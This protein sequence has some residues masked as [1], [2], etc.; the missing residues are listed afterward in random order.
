MEFQKLVSIFQELEATSSGNQMREILSHFLKQVP[1]EEIDLVS[2]L[3]LGQIASQYRDINLGMAE[4]MVIK[5]LSLASGTGEEKL[6]EVLKQKGDLGLAAEILI[7]KKGHGLGSFALGKETLTV[8]KVFQVLH[9]ISQASGEGSQ[10]KKISLLASLLKEASPLEA[11]YL[12]RIVLGTLRLGVAAMTVLDALSIA[13]TGTKANKPELEHAYNI[14]PDIGIIA[15]TLALKG[16]KGISSI[17]VVVGRPINMMLAQRVTDLEEIKKHI[18]G[19]VSTEEKYDGERIQA[20]QTK[21]KIILFSRRM[22][23]I[24]DQFPDVV[25]YLHQSIKAKEYVIEGEVVAID[26]KGNLLPFQTLMQ[27]RRKYQVEKYVKEIPIRF[28]LFDLLYLDGKSYLREPYLERQKALEKIVKPSFHLQIAN[29]ITTK[30]LDKIEEFFNQALER[31]TEGII[32]KSTAED[33]VYQAGTRGWLWIKWKREYAKEIQ[34]TF[35]L[36]IVGAFAGR[37]KRS[38]TYGALLCAAYNDKKDT[39]ETVCKLGSGFSD[40]QLFE[41]PKKLK[42][43][44]IPHKPARLEIHK[45]MKPD[46]WFEP[47]VVVEVL[48]AELTK[49]PIHTCNEKEGKGIAL[50]FPRFVRLR[51]DKSPEQATT[52]HE[53][54]DMLKGKK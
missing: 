20:H 43:Y 39:F 6:K 31:G 27:R 29:K 38:G 10:E 21:N 52:S 34:D 54:E 1:K 23:N 35:D 44:Q 24:T 33:S 40:E 41:L 4:K 37:G 15:K 46:F 8:K 53:I 51:E 3:I 32:A 50:R 49:S 7:K 19:P 5:S 26:Q 48:G 22:E 17:D 13:F 42:K 47:K 14:C 28:Y 16:L 12:T 2:Y 36:V 18:E 11:K 9:Q 25:D 45:E 30:D